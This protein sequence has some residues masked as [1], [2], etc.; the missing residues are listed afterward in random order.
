MR[1]VDNAF[2]PLDSS[3]HIT[4]PLKFHLALKLDKN[5][6]LCVQEFDFEFEPSIITVYNSNSS[7]L[8]LKV[9]KI[10]VKGVSG[11]RKYGVKISFDGLK[12]PKMNFKSVKWA[13]F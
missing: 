9:L 6:A 12:T 2:R 5:L 13:K 10:W 1:Y 4:E 3:H 7:I 11:L 8:R